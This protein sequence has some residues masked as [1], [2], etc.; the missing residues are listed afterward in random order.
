MTTAMRPVSSGPPGHVPASNAESD[1]GSDPRQVPKGRIRRI[2]EE[3]HIL[4]ILLAGFGLIFLLIFPPSLVVNDSWLN[5]MAG[6]E[7]I[8]NGLPSV[9]E[10]TIYGLGSV[11]TDQQW[12]A[13]VLMYGLYSLGGVALLSIAAWGIG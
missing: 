11:W 10:L 4:V 3:E 13:Q 2:A 1:P 9:D 7:V 12:G 6:R 5:L 8:E